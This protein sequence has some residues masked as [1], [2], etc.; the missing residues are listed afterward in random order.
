MK[1]DVFPRAVSQLYLGLT[2]LGIPSWV[3]SSD[4]KYVDYLNPEDHVFT[5]GRGNIDIQSAD[6]LLAFDVR[7]VK[8]GYFIPP[9]NELPSSEIKGKIDAVI[10]LKGDNNAGRYTSVNVSGSIK[11]YANIL[12]DVS[13]GSSSFA[14]EDL[15]ID[16]RLDGLIKI[17]S[18]EKL[19]IEL[20]RVTV[21]YSANGVNAS[22]MLDG[23]FRFSRKQFRADIRQASIGLSAPEIGSWSADVTIN[24]LGGF[25]AN[26][27]ENSQPVATISADPALNLRLE[28]SSS[29]LSRFGIS[30]AYINSLLAGESMVLGDQE[31]SEISA[32]LGQNE[33]D[34]NPVISFL[35]GAE[36]NSY[37]VEDVISDFLGL[38][39]VDLRLLQAGGSGGSTGSGGGGGGG[40]GGGSGGGSSS[41]SAPPTTSSTTTSTTTQPTEP[42]TTTTSP[43]PVTPAP[44]QESPVLGIQPQETVTTVQLST[45]VLVGNLQITQAVVGTPQ[46]D[47]IIGSNE[48]EVLSGGQGKDQL[49]GGAGP[50]AFLFE[51]PGEFGK[52][53]A[54]VVTDF[55]PDEGDVLAISQE[56][57]SGVTRIKFKSASG[58]REAKQQGRS[59]KNFIYDEKK[60]M[61]YYDANG[62][63]NGWGDGGEF[64]QLLGAPE[65]GKGDLVL[66]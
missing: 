18:A 4:Q 12:G 60:G 9:E 53:S 39:S 48:G 25:T 28:L 42:T 57:F 65:I 32:T 27:K 29:I 6:D 61:L 59:N 41:S 30:D 8:F 3:S 58:K 20:D 66:V 55:N 47:V 38:N 19:S 37:A 14:T 35:A 23:D 62:K 16:I 46:R 22:L 36:Q 31:I 51:T 40:G 44:S 26:F 49:T 43:S 54:D 33:S 64:A 11:G 5:F 63:K 21:N 34:L 17:P 7:G 1:P 15:G 56:A 24:P 13:K 2:Q 52:E 50:D 45:P 10:A